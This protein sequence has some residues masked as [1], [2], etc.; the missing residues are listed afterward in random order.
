MAKIESVT[1]WINRGK[2]AVV[3]V[4]LDDGQ[5]ACVWVG[6]SVEVFHDEKHDIVKAF[7]KRPSHKEKP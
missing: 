1:G 5:E 2:D 7:V 3:F 4:V 6:G